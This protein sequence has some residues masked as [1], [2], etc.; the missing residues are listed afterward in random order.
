M[1]ISQAPVGPTTRWSMFAS[2]DP[3]D[4]SHLR[5]SA[6]VEV[7]PMVSLKVGRHEMPPANDEPVVERFAQARRSR[8]SHPGREQGRDP[9]APAFSL[10]AP[11]DSNPEPAD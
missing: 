8:R 2:R 9:K 5:P 1:S 7:G 3:W 4:C 6:S 10:Y 11:R